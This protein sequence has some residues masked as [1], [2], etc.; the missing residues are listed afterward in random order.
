MLDSYPV[1]IMRERI[2]RNTANGYACALIAAG[3]W[4]NQITRRNPRGIAA[5][6]SEPCRATFDSLMAAPVRRPIV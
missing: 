1:A 5:P 3:V 2:A 4:R 6:A